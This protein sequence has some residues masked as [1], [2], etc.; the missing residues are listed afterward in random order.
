MARAYVYMEVSEYPPRN[1]L[2]LRL[3]PLP[4]AGVFVD[5]PLVAS[6]SMNQFFGSTDERCSI[7]HLTGQVRPVI[8]WSANALSVAYTVQVRFVRCKYGTYSLWPFYI[9][10]FTTKSVCWPFFVRYLSVTYALFM[11]LMRPLH[12]PRR[13]SSSPRRHS[14]KDEHRINIFAVFCPL[15]VRYPYPLMC[16]STTRYRP[17]IPWSIMQVIIFA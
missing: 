13:P 4:F 11:R 17:F 2:G 7:R 1:P 3:L 10:Y 9:R 5:F 6:W 12:V 14:S 16:E 15:G 8:V